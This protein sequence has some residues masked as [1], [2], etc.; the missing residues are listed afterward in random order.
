MSRDKCIVFGINVVGINIVIIYRHLKVH[1]YTKKIYLYMMI[2][3]S[4]K[5]FIFFIWVLLIVSCCNGA[6]HF[7]DNFQ[8]STAVHSSVRIL[9]MIGRDGWLVTWWRL[10]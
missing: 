2:L 9:K 3:P 5:K 4:H 6:V 1:I 10:P 8:L 7:L